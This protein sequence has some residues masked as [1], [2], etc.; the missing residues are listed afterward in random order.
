LVIISDLK[1]ILKLGKTSFGLP[2]NTPEW[3]SPITSIIPGQLFA[4]QLAI[5]KGFDSDNPEGLL[6][7]TQTY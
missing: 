2:K 3:L 6:K 4:R 1:K 7:I 5:E